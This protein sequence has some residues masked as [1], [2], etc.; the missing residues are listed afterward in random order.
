MRT[1]A[2]PLM[3]GINGGICC[4]LGPWDKPKDDTLGH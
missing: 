4:T 1:Q 3:S 2:A